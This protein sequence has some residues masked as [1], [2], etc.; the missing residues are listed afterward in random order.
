MRTDMA[1]QQRNRKKGDVHFQNGE[2]GMATDKAGHLRNKRKA[3][4]T[5]SDKTNFGISGA[6]FSPT[7][8][9]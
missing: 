9:W 8:R 4:Y 7:T 2:T 6:T 3:T 5:S 1:G